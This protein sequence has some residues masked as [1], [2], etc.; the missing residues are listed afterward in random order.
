MGFTESNI[1]LDFPDNKWFRFEDKSAYQQLSGFSFKEMDACWYDEANQT[2]YLIELKD[3]TSGNIENQENATG[4]V[5][6]LLKKSIDSLQMV[7][8]H[9]LTTDIGNELEQNM[10]YT[11]PTNTQLVFISIID[12]NQSQRSDLGFIRDTYKNKFK[13]YEKLFNL[14]SS[15]ISYENA[16][17]RF[18]WVN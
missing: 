5:H 4:R 2:F 7:L 1:T 13:A 10:G 6:N 14:K 18:T 3:F 15:V 9:Q 17:Q 8:A 12:I 11:I 16:K